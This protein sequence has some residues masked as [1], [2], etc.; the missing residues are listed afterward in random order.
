MAELSLQ[1]YVARIED[2]L[3]GDHYDE[4]L[5]PCRWLLRLLPWYGKAYYLL[6]QVYLESEDLQQAVECFQ[7][8]LSVDPEHRAAWQG[9]GRARDEQGQFLEA[10]WALRQALDLAPGDGEIQAHL[11]HLCGRLDGRGNAR[12]EL[13]HGALARLYLRNGLLEQAIDQFQLAFRR[14]PSWPGARLPLAEAL[15]QAE[16]YPEALEVS[17]EVLRVLPHCLKANL[18]AGGILLQTGQSDAAEAR[19]Q[20][21]QAVDPENMMAQQVLGANPRLPTVEIRIPEPGS[22]GLHPEPEEET[23]GGWPPETMAAMAAEPEGLPSGALLE[24]ALPEPSGEP[25]PQPARLGEAP[26]SLQALVDAG[27]LDEVDLTVGLAEL[28]ALRAGD[29]QI[30]GPP[31]PAAGNLAEE[32]L[33][34]WIQQLILPSTVDGAQ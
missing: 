27:I 34:A 9:L 21:A 28:A 18:I 31:D 17:L 24:G 25:A 14:G 32:E 2:L 30:E 6:G 19:F 15:W 11:Q 23:P 3:Q 10:A 22:E 20:I 1:Q 16:R 7:R 12:P 4:A 13:T 33:A 29:G 8:A 5:A 26:A